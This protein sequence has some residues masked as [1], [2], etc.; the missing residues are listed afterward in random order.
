MSAGDATLNKRSG[1]TIKTVSCL[2]VKK[3]GERCTRTFKGTSSTR[4]CPTCSRRKE[5][6]ERALSTRF[7]SPHAEIIR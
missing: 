4:F 5:G 3:N 7:L 6:I 1:L 2:G